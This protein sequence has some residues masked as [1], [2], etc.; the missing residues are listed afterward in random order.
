[1]KKKGFTLIE[2]LVVIA[3]IAL[4]MAIIMPA[5]KVAKKQAQAV[6]CLAHLRQVTCAWY[7]YADENAGNVVG[8]NDKVTPYESIFF[9]QSGVAPAYSWVCTPQ[10]EGGSE[11]GSDSTVEEEIE[12][13]PLGWDK[14][15]KQDNI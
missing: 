15:I 14:A 9:Q 11:R 12:G 5:L 3:I 2:L 8:A 10:D 6:V 13:I 4:L 1:M 7:L